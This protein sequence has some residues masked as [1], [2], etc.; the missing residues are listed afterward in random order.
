[1]LW[2]RYK[3]TL[4]YLECEAGIG[5]KRQMKVSIIGELIEHSNG[6]IDL[7]GWVFDCDCC[8]TIYEA[9]FKHRTELIKLAKQAGT[10]KYII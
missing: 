6:V 8:S 1:L 5:G 10:Y 9:A 7:F 3:E 4:Y 2:P